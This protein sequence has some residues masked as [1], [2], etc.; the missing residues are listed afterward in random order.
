[1]S[2]SYYGVFYKP[3]GV[4]GYNVRKYTEQSDVRSFCVQHVDNFFAQQKISL[5]SDWSMQLT[6]EEIIFSAIDL[7]T[8][9]FDA[10][11]N[12]VVEYEDSDQ[13]VCSASPAKTVYSASSARL[14]KNLSLLLP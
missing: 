11:I 2:R 10:K 3:L 5:P 13:T 7:P 8:E 9:H 1:M 12:L 6:L 4:A 14:H